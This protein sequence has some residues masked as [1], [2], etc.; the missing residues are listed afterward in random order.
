MVDH[1]LLT[2]LFGLILGIQHAFEADHMAAV[3]AMTVEQKNPLKASL[4]GTFWGIGHT[5]TLFVMGMLVLLFRI[6]IPER[7]GLGLEFIV[8][9]M[10][11]FLG[12][13][14]LL[15][16]R[17]TAHDKAH[18]PMHTHERATNHHRR[19]FLV[20]TVHG[21]AGSGAV[22]LLV[23]STISDTLQGLYYILLFG[24]GSILG[25]TIMSLLVGLPFFLSASRFPQTEKY[26]KITAGILSIFFGLNL[27]YQ[28]GF[29]DG[30]F[31]KQ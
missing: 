17:V 3:T 14:T 7:I 10:L 15:K 2:L 18:S 30:L 20:G 31:I 8:G 25:M 5:T 6:T 22:T 4:V 23:L 9:C 29:I 11:V 19:S 1:E 13:R 21:L 12:V 16:S 27:M 24:I 28:I 26:L